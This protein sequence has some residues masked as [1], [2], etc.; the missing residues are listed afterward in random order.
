MR[1]GDSVGQYKVT[2][3]LGQGGMG[4][5]FKAVDTM[6][7]REV[8]IKVLRP[9][10]ARQPNLLQRFRAEAVTLA[11]LNHAGI[12][13]LYTFLQQGE[14]FF[15]VLEYVPGKTLEAVERERGALSYKIA[16]PLFARILEAMQAAHDM[17]ILHRDVKPANI[18]LTTWGTVKLMDFGIARV[19]GAARQT[20]QGALVG[21]MEYIAPERVK[22][23]EGDARGDIY[24]LGIVLYEMLTG[25]LPFSSENEFE[26]MRM[27]LEVE[28]PSFKQMGVSVPPEIEQVVWRSIAKNEDDRY[29]SC[30]EFLQVLQTANGNAGISKK[31][32]I[33][34]VGQITVRELGTA[35]HRA[36][37][38]ETHNLQAGN[39][40]NPALQSTRSG[41]AAA[42]PLAGLMEFVRTH[43]VPIA[44]VGAALLAIAGGIGA[45]LMSRRTPQPPPAVVITPP[46]DQTTPT[47]AAADV[48]EGQ[49]SGGQG[50][51]APMPVDGQG[52]PPRK[53]PIVTL[54][55]Q[56]PTAPAEP[57]PK[58]KHKSDLHDK[59]LRALDQ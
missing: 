40:T 15:M 30:D 12:A 29:S 37:S 44:A 31:E 46:T 25:R 6:I 56:V 5:V 59:S 9:E 48:S 33:A 2:E 1:I 22:G 20:R 52:D 39:A 23:K 10:I 47:P 58:P 8:A 42:A 53:A 21:T 38:G 3:L 11:K 28:P 51:S 18:M 19:L 50:S 54:P 4:E 49:G 17:D 24:S 26:M 36:S 13:T 7:D 57:A 34:L 16:V 45:G 43:K 55:V 35:G 14:D 41:V 32:I 27:H